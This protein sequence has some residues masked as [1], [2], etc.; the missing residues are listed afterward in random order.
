MSVGLGIFLSTV[1]IALVLFY[2]FTQDRLNWKKIIRSIGLALGSLMLM[3]AIIG[4]GIFVYNTVKSTPSK[5]FGYFDLKIGMS[6]PEVQYVKGDPTNVLEAE[7]KDGG[8]AVVPVNALKQGDKIENYWFWA[9]ELNDGLRL[10]VVFDKKTKRLLE[11]AC[12]S[13]GANECPP[14]LGIS[15]GTNEDDLVAKL[16]HPT[17]EKMDGSAKVMDYDKLGAHFYLTKKQ[18]YMMTV[19]EK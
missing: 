16:G 17:R 12:Y 4:T 6:M 5:Q 10:D 2:R 18:V 14:L 3:G 8:Q 9:Y 1:V 7:I 11:I 19:A 15:D 13:R